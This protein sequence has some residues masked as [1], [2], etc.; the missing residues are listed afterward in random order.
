MNKQRYICKCI[1][2]SFFNV[3][4]HSHPRHH[5]WPTTRMSIV[6]LCVAW[7]RNER[8]AT[9]RENQCMKEDERIH[10]HQEERPPLTIAII[11]MMIATSRRLFFLMILYLNPLL[12]GKSNKTLLLRWPILCDFSWPPNSH[13]IFKYHFFV[14]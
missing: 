8:T 13:Q 2:N 14:R 4:C 12:F 6:L 11:M 10:L 3:H 7:S 1:K 5:V 9:Q